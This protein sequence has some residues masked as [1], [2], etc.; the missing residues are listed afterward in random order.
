MGRRL[1]VVD[2]RCL[3]SI[4]HLSA[5]QL[6]AVADKEVFTFGEEATRMFFVING[7][8]N[9]IFGAVKKAKTPVQVRSGAHACEM[10]LWAQWEHRGRLVA[11]QY[12]DLVALDSLAFRRIICRSVAF[13]QC[14]EYARLYAA[15]VAEE[16]DVNLTRMP[17]VWLSVEEAW[18]I[19]SLAF[20][21]VDGQ[22]TFALSVGD[23]A[24][25]GG[26]SLTFG[27]YTRSVRIGDRLRQFAR[28]M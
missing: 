19:S 12:S 26:Q 16:F 9:Y 6:S 14:R 27:L 21:V 13:S 15:K 22:S 10:V 1:S 24:S 28:R 25:S 18:Q 3:A 7:T 8:L 4:C 2:E 23:G 20:D 17:D 5:E 11:T